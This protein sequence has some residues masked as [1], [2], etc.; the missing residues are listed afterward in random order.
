L[1]C[2][3]IPGAGKT[4]LTSI[5]VQELTTRFSNDPTI[6]IAYLYCSFKRHDEQKAKDLLASLLKQLAQVQPSLPDSI[7]SLYDNHNLKHTRPSLDELSKILQSVATIYSRVFIIVDALDECREADGDRAKLLADISNLQVNSKVNLFA[8]SRII[9]DIEK[10]FKNCLLL[11][12]CANHEDI[13]NYSR[14]YPNST[15]WARFC[16]HNNFLITTPII[17]L[18]LIEI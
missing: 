16:D 11:E 4:I 1:F 9:P 17:K 13:W 10:N 12:I 3:G 5:V 7:K 18:F 15:K 6:S 8:T 14:S 2:P